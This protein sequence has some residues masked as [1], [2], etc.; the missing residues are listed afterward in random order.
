MRAQLFPGGVSLVAALAGTK[1][2]LLAITPAES[3]INLDVHDT[4]AHRSV[5]THVF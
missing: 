5:P 4:G 1:T 2:L 3:L